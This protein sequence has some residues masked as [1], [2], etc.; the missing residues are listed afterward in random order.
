MELVGVII[1]ALVAIGVIVSMADKD[2]I[3]IFDIFI[4]EDD[5]NPENKD[6]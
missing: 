1:L 5:V 6:K 3:N 4:E 2:E